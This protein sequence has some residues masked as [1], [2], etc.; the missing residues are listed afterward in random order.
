MNLPKYDKLKHFLI[1]YLISLTLPLIGV[2]ALYICIAVAVGKE[3][4]D[5]ISKKGTPE[6]MDMVWTVLPCALNYLILT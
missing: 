6:I 4:Y 3:L 2:Y 1:G 5:K